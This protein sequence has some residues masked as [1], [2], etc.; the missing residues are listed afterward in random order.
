[1][2]TYLKQVPDSN[3]PQDMTEVRM[4]FSL[5][6][7]VNG[8]AGTCHGGLIGLMLDEV[9]GQL[10]AEVFGRYNIITAGL[11]VAYKRKLSTPAVVLCRAWLGEA[12]D[13]KL[14]IEGTIEDG[15]GG[16]YAIGQTVFVKTD[17][18]L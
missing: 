5:G 3:T 11:Q 4:V 16:V 6:D 18:R 7:G 2:Q 8:I 12:K 13:R 9:T 10:A 17:S 15:M 1:M 14:K